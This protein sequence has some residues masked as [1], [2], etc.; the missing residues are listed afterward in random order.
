[1]AHEMPFLALKDLAPAGY[2]IGLRAGF[3]FPRF[4]MSTLSMAWV[5]TYSRHGWFLEDPALRWSQETSG[6]IRWSELASRDPAGLIPLSAEFGMRFGAIISY[7]GS[8][9]NRSYGLFF[10]N[11][12]EYL[13][14][15]LAQMHVHLEEKHA[16][17]APPSAPLSTKEVLTLKHMKE[18]RRIKGTAHALGITESAVKLRL[19]R[20]R[21][22]LG[23]ATGSHAVIKAAMLGLLPGKQS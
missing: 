7:H 1:M 5:E 17:F 21:T 13:D 4:R 9:T 11:D 12:R 8:L 19:K 2:F 14:H 6:T 23:V 3:I 16:A 10:R 15:E 20:A 22:K 18:G